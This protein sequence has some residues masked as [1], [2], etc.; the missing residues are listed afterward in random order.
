MAVPGRVYN[1]LREEIAVL[2]RLIDEA[3]EDGLGENDA[4][5]QAYL[6]TLHKREQLLEDL[7]QAELE[8]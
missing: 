5:L 3:L 8:A 7:E 4:R 6:E 1:D 2:R